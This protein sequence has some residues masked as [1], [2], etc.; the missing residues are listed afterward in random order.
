MKLAFVYAGQGSQRVGMGQD[1]YEQYPAFRAFLDGLSLDFDVKRLCF[2]G[3]GEKLSQTRYTQ[4]CM[5]AFAVGVTDLLLAEGVVPQAAAGL[6]LGEYS[7]LY[8]AGVFDR[9]T[10]L[11][12]VALRGRVMEEAAA[13]LACGMTAVLGL[14]RDNLQRA[15]DGASALGVVQ[16]CNYNCPGQLVIGGEKAAVDR[17]GELAKELGARRCM[18]LKVSGPF[19]TRLMRP[20]GD[21]LR[22]HFRTIPFGAMRFPVYF[23]CTGDRMGPEDTIPALLERQVQSPVRWEDTIRALERDGFDTVVEIGPGRTLSGFFKKTAPGIRTY[24]IDTAEDFR[25]VVSEW[26]GGAQ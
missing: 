9:R 18:P 8:A 4:P 6:S 10:V 21:A 5:A 25:K 14:D 24:S 13:G 17:A 11:D 20:A 23:N 22:E 2:E 16:I 7:A 3:P 15:C 19:H 26:K 12:T 1:F